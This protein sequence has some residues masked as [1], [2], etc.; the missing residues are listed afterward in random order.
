MANA[1]SMTRLLPGFAAL[2]LALGLG[3]G[4]CASSGAGG[5]A[6]SAADATKYETGYAD[7][8]NMDFGYSDQQKDASFDEASATKVRLGDGAGG[9][10]AAI[11]G[12]GAEASPEGVR[13]TQAGTYVLTGSMDDGQLRVEA[14]DDAQVRLVLAG[15]QIANADGPAVFAASGG[16]VF[17]TLVEGFENSLVDGGQRASDS[18]ENEGDAALYSEVDLCLNGSGTLTVDG[19]YAHGISSKAGLVVTGG[20]YAV[21][22][23]DDAMR[24]ED[25]VKVLDGSFDL[26]PAG[27]AVKSGNSEDPTRG[28]VSID[29]GA[30]SINAGD[31]GVN[32]F[33]YFRIA[34]GSFDVT[35]AGDAFKSDADGCVSGGELVINAGDDAVHAE[36][37][38][39]VDGGTVDVL[40]CA[41]GYEAERVYLNGATTHIVSSDDAI[42]AAAPETEAVPKEGFETSVG[43]TTEN[44]ETCLIRFNEGYTV[45][46]AGGDGI[47]SDGYVEVNGGILLVEGPASS[48]DGVFDY[49]LGAE[50]TGGTVLMVGAA[51]MAQS[52][53]GGTQPFAMVQV[54]GLAGQ[55]VALTA[56]GDDGGESGELLASFT[57]KRDYQVVIVSSPAMTD[58]VQYDLCIGVDIPDANADGFADGGFV[59][60]D[61]FVQFTAST[62]PSA[63]PGGMG[64]RGDMAPG[65]VAPDGAAPEDMAPGGMAPGGMSR[66]DA[67]AASPDGTEPPAAP[68]DGIE[69]PAA[70]PD[71][72][73]SLSA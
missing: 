49:G 34:G 1:T 9:V 70:P 19:S 68:P 57:P 64:G 71:G 65:G 12:E 20:S 36:F 52:F 21:T 32:A 18:G 47:D 39:S 62:T 59:K 5:E 63:G 44:V 4:G 43:A 38:L 66:P 69:P 54:S 24:A 22:A 45:I 51:G 41:E 42:N 46:D 27:D 6:S 55:S 35:A 10:L 14:P 13:I 50:V 30:F 48:A 37:T 33:S 16:E 31:D 56:Q 58:G 40:A 3:L 29:G 8:E 25:W 28:F 15:A 72:A 26:E 23:A 17:V 53:S 7:V 60:A 61:T 2:C 67:L 11:E 73:E